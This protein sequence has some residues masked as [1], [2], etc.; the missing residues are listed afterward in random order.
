[1]LLTVAAIGAAA[2]AALV[3][4]PAAHVAVV[5]FGTTALLYLVVV[6]LLREAHEGMGE[7]T[8]WI[9]SM[10]FVGFF[11]ALL[12]ERAM[13][14]GSE[15]GSEMVSAVSLLEAPAATL[16]ETTMAE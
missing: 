5:S 14:S 4:Y 13:S 8:V 15:I 16:L 11:V 6:E 2:A 1:V 10:F 12:L 9:E 3:S 7:S